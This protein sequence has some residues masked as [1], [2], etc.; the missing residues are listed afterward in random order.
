MSAFRNFII[1]VMAMI[2][3]ASSS[4]FQTCR[5]EYER[6]AQLFKKE[7]NDQEKQRLFV[8]VR[9]KAKELLGIPSDRKLVI[10]PHIEAMCKLLDERAKNFEGESKTAT[11]NEALKKQRE[12][13]YSREIS[14]F[15]KVA[16]KILETMSSDITI[17]DELLL[18]S[19]STVLHFAHETI[20]MLQVLRYFLNNGTD[21]EGIVAIMR[22]FATSPLNGSYLLS[23]I[24][25]LGMAN[26]TALEASESTRT[27]IK[28]PDFSDKT[29]C[30]YLN[31]H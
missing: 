4:D 23:V 2:S 14:N 28:Q 8:L 24:M 21:I 7:T 5:N 15:L 30:K 20:I 25:S 12:S 17:L 6:V 13:E 3:I 26:P 22:T 29:L 31:I 18:K 19:P 16:A 9:D 11:G 27:L 10:S 1:V